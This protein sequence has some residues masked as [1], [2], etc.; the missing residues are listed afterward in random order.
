[1]QPEHHETMTL[2]SP[3]GQIGNELSQVRLLKVQ[4]RSCFLICAELALAPS[5]PVSTSRHAWPLVQL[6]QRKT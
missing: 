3:R 1:M 6:F 4:L 2:P 5:Y